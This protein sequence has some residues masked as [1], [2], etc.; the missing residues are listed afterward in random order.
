MSLEGQEHPETGLKD[1][2][3][4]LVKAPPEQLLS[5][6][7][8]LGESLEENLLHALCLIVLQKEVRALDKLQTLKD[9]YFASQLAVKLQI[10]EGKLEAFAE[11]CGSFPE[12]AG[13]SLAALARIFKV[14]SEKRM[15]DPRLRDLAYKRALLSDNQAAGSCE[16]LDY[17]L[18][19][20]EAKGVCGPQFAEWACS[21]KDLRSEPRQ[22]LEGSLDAG[23]TTLK[24]TLSQ[25]QCERADS[26]PSPLQV[27]SSMPSYPTHL[28]ISVPPT[29]TFPDDKE[30]PG[31]SD[32]SKLKTKPALIVYECEAKNTLGQTLS[33]QP[34][35]TQAPPSGAKK[36][37]K[38]KAEGSKNQPTKA[39]VAPTSTNVVL[40]KAP[41]PESKY[42]EGD[43]KAIFYD[44]VILH[45]QEDEDEAERMREKVGAVI[46]SEG[47]TLAGDFAVPG[48]RSL[49]C[50][51]DAINNSAFT[52]LLLTRNFNEGML[53]IQADSALI[54]SINKRHK[55]N[56]VIPLLPK[57]NSMPKESLPMVL[58][59]IN[60]LEEN[61]AF[62]RKIKKIFTP[63]KIENQKKIWTVEQAVKRE[64]ERQERL[65]HLN[66]AQQE[67]IKECT[68]AQLLVQENVR[69]SLEGNYLESVVSARPSIHIENANYV[70]IG[71]DST[72]TVSGAADK[73]DSGEEQ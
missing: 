63:R 43:E 14:L 32:E 17:D 3:D 37:S 9:N 53:D 36:H 54:N 27:T 66:Q 42:A 46:G 7:F 26:L 21:P 38:M 49:R 51:E 19:A 12:L 33:P 58:G 30:T 2:F 8:L 29:A 55:Y 56:T 52:F 73:D 20:E 1:V 13:G 47:A 22:D 25:D 6:T 28:E 72:M 64:I 60:P 15:C 4:I 35:S 68:T 59:T 50:V 5:L 31:T 34:E 16:K 41:V 18:L 61:K 11:H 23:N 40:P 48:K 24:V 70:M 45:D 65:K 71:N 57:E 67:M 44:F 62:D 69:L 39:T 10:S